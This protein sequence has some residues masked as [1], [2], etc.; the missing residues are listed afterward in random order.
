MNDLGIELSKLVFK[1]EPG[2][3]NADP[4]AVG[5]A[6]TVVADLLG[7]VMAAVLKQK[8]EATYTHAMKLMFERAHQSAVKTAA[9]ANNMPPETTN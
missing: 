4:H 1:A 3:L 6:A 5:R 2:L 9:A 7:C 8:G